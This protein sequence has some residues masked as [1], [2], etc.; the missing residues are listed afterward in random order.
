MFP[1]WAIDL[2]LADRAG[3]RCPFKIRDITKVKKL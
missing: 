1:E 2:L 3:T